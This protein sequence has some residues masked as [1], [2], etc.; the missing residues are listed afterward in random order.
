MFRTKTILVLGI[1]ALLMCC[2][3]AYAADK[4]GKTAISLFDTIKNGGI[5]GFF[6]ILLSVASLALT[7]EHAI[8]IRRDALVPPELLGHL[9]SLFE[10]EEYEE[11]M[12]LCESTPNFL[13]NVIAAGL[14]KIGQGYEAIEAAMQEAGENEAVKLNQ[15]ISYLSLIANIAPMMGL[16]GTVIGMIMAFNVIARS[17]AAPSPAKLA[18]GISVALVTTALGLFVAIPTMCFYFFFRNRVMRVVM[19]VATIS[20]ELME[21]FRPAE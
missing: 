6:I 1:F 3:V 20:E 21:R 15:K 4:S 10:D 16:F 11:A 12:T 5:I 8:T 14:P 19:E 18:G 2:G 17:E 7:I 13:T 9:E